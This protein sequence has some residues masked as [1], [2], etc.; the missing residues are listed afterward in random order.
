MQ[1]ST[2]SP[3]SP[4]DEVMESEKML[5]ARRAVKAATTSDSGKPKC[6][7][8]SI[9]RP[10][11]R[12]GKNQGAISQPKFPEVLTNYTPQKVPQSQ[13]GNL[14]CKGGGT[15]VRGAL[16]WHFS[17]AGRPVTSTGDK[18]PG[19]ACVLEQPGVPGGACSLGPWAGVC[20]GRVVRSPV[21]YTAR[22]LPRIWWPLHLGPHA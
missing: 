16:S 13:G 21:G 4:G 11:D 9:T 2:G 6:R 7:E 15:A 5:I 1:V 17:H 12:L 19:R 18:G 22:L 10:R 3:G 20:P 8:C 14:L